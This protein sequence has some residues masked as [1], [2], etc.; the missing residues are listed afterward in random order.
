[1]ALE[2]NPVPPVQKPVLR[3][4]LEPQERDTAGD[5]LNA[6]FMGVNFQP[7]ID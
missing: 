4:N 7:Q 2:V 6:G 3:E 5:R 1:M